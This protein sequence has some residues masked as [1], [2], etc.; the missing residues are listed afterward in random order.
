[1]GNSSQKV[2]VP[3]AGA[4]ATYE[5][6]RLVLLGTVAELTGTGTGNPNDASGM[7]SK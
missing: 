5:R 3:I 7:G 1:M 6:P 2:S 4:P